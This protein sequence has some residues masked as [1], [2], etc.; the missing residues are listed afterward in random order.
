MVVWARVVRIHGVR[1]I[2]QRSWEFRRLLF[3]L[4]WR[5]DLSLLPL[6]VVFVTLSFGLSVFGW[7]GATLEV[8]Q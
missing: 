5:C 8:L 6:L 1:N 4:F 7:L 2:E 3:W